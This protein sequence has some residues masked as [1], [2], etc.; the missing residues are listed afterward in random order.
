MQLTQIYHV[1]EQP[2]DRFVLD[3]QRG[4]VM[5]RESIMKPSS[6]DKI[7]RGDAVYEVRPDGTFMVDE[8]TAAFLL[9]TPGWHAGPNPF[10]V[11]VEIEPA[12]PPVVTKAKSRAS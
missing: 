3:P 2:E 9:S 6:R 7:T 4:P 5:R 1:E 8:H 12:Q 10:F 11:D